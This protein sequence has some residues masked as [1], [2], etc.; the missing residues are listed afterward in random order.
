MRIV[1]V[2]FYWPIALNCAQISENCGRGS[3]FPQAQL[4]FQAVAHGYVRLQLLRN[5]EI[6]NCTFSR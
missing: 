1:V 3:C 6:T 4:T 5:H 2:H